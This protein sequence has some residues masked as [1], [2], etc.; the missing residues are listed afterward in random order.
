MHTP[1][2]DGL[3]ATGNLPRRASSPDSRVR[4]K[5]LELFFFYLMESLWF[6]LAVGEGLLLV[7][8]PRLGTL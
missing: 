3:M 8:M 2:S 6:L 4:K 7:V 5:F 1:G